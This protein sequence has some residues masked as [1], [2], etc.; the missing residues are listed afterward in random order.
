MSKNNGKQNVL[1]VSLDDGKMSVDF[2]SGVSPVMIS[3][4]LRMASLTFDNILIGQQ[5]K[6]DESAIE[7]PSDV[8][9]RM[10]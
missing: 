2:G 4:A 1:T 7:L 3:H 9:K 6:M 5:A 10:R 8:V